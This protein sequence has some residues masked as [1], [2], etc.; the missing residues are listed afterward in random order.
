MNKLSCSWSVSE[1]R[2]GVKLGT[3]DA[4][5][6][7]EYEEA[8]LKKVTNLTTA[9]SPDDVKRGERRTYEKGSGPLY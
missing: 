3:R 2:R 9:K 5:T 7:P 1:G 8:M 6:H 4:L